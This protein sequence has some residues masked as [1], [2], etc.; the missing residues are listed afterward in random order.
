MKEIENNPIEEIDIRIANLQAVIDV[1]SFEL[2][3]LLL[4]KKRLSEKRQIWFIINW[5]DDNKRLRKKKTISGD[6]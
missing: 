5:W 2:N 3:H 4:E 1:V 6:G